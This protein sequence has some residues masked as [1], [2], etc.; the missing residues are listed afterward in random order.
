MRTSFYRQSDVNVPVLSAAPKSSGAENSVALKVSLEQYY[1]YLQYYQVPYPFILDPVVV[2]PQYTL[3]VSYLMAPK[4]NSTKLRRPFVM[5]D[6]FDPKDQ[7]DYRETRHDEADSKLLPYERDH[8]GLFHYLNGDPSPWYHQNSDA[9]FVADLRNYGYDIVFI[10]FM[11]G[12]GDVNTNA[13]LLRGFI[14]EVLNGVNF[15]DNQTEEMILVGPS[16]GG[17]ITRI[18]LTTMEQHRE[19]HFVKTWISFD[20]PHKGANITMALQHAVN[21]GTKLNTVGKE[22]P[23]DSKKEVLCSPAAKQLLGEH[24]LAC[25]TTKENVVAAAPDAMYTSLQDKLNKLKF[26]VFSK[27][28]AL[29]NG[30]T[31]P[32]YRRGGYVLDFSLWYTWYTW[33]EG[34]AGYS[35]DR[36]YSLK[37]SRQGGKEN[38]MYANTIPYDNAPGGWTDALYSFNF[39]KSNNGFLKDEKNISSKWS[40]F[41]PTSSAF[42]VIGNTLLQKRSLVLKNWK[43]FTNCNDHASGKIMTPFDAIL[44]MEGNQQHMTITYE[45][46]KY[47]ETYWL[48]VDLTGTTRPIRRNGPFI[49]QTVSK[50]VAYRVVESIAF[51]GNHNKISFEKGADVNIVAGKNILFTD[52]FST[53]KGAKMTA[54]IQKMDITYAPT[55]KTEGMKKKKTQS[56]AYLQES[57]FLRKQYDYDN[58]RELPVESEVPLKILAQ[59]NPCIDKL[60]VT[61]NGMQSEN[62]LIELLNEFG[63]VFLKQVI[64]KNETF[65]MDLSKL[66]AGV[67]FLKVK[68]DYHA[69]LLK[70]IKM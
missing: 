24:F 51:G 67:Y 18:A 25:T 22:N 39:N 26:P 19:E 58:K 8:R 66:E 42:G 31:L 20:A 1:P 59:P 63:Q 28:Y 9:N 14:K 44:G 30:G 53:K 48:N 7:R 5:V 50:P 54:R 62:A 70:I 57:S 3:Q 16:M 43:D 34:W 29:T 56:A 65:T 32:L 12:D 33:M 52:G 45:T 15:R 46:K 41:I 10:N 61:V 38:I 11:Y 37:A 4:N 68:D 13:D 27:N 21:F 60:L 6:G 69:A 55:G 35:E 2:S 23:F 17:L 36:A 40:T 47:I 64:F 49:S